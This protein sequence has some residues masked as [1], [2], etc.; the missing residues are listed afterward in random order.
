MSTVDPLLIIFIC[1][2][3][4]RQNQLRYLRVIALNNTDGGWTVVDYKTLT[5]FYFGRAK[6]FVGTLTFFKEKNIT[7]EYEIKNKINIPFDPLV[8]YI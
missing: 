4:S 8:S 7:G 5:N 6:H 1:F 2:F 3:A